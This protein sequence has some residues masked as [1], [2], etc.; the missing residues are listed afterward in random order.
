MM[1]VFNVIVYKNI[2]FYPYWVQY[3][4]NKSSK[5]TGGR[6]NGSDANTGPLGIFLHILG[7]ASY[8]I[9]VQHNCL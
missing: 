2:D 1:L 5:P 9:S 4:S 8:G 6:P 3:A 7:S